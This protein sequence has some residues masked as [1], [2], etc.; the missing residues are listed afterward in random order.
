MRFGSMDEVL[1]ALRAGHA[2]VFPTDTVYGIGAAVM[3]A[4]SPREIFTAKQRDYDKAVPWLVGRDA[5]LTTFGVNVPEY[6]RLLVQAFW[7][8]PLTIVVSASKSVPHSFASAEGTVALRMPN[9]QTA[10]DLIARVGCPIAASS[11]NFQ[12]CPPPRTYL[13]I[14]QDFLAQLT[15]ACGDDVSRS[16]LS[17]T[18]VDC[19]GR[20]PRMLRV[21]EISADEVNRVAGM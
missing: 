18:I 4:T 6:A 15:A 11:A 2:A 7:P 12:G 16:G 1:C 10:L 9:D 17:S 21:G 8:G 20:E 13:D 19:T 14:D 5:A 3:R